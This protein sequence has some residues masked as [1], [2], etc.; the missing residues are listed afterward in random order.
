VT[1]VDR[2]HF[3]KRLFPRYL[4]PATMTAD[5]LERNLAQGSEARNRNRDA[6][7]KEAA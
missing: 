7:L 4:T 3:L 6:E 5:Q 1:F 2:V